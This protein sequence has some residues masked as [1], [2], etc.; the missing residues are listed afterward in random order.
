[1]IYFIITVGIIIITSMAIAAYSV[2][3]LWKDYPDDG[4]YN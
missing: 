3:K 1:M 4:G 2:Y